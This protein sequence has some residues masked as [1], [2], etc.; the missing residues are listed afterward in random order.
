MALDGWNDEWANEDV[1]AAFSANVFALRTAKG[2]TQKQL[3][4]RMGYT[5]IIISNMERGLQGAA[6][7]TLL[8]LAWALDSTPDALLA[9][10]VT[11]TT[12]TTKKKGK[13]Q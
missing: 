10:S 8:R 9:R 3:A 4:D 13:K 7:P 1:W 2:L 6:L 5:R 12:K 11:V